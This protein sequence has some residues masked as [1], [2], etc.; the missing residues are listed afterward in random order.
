MDSNSRHQNIGMVLHGNVQTDIRVQNEINFLVS[1]GYN[2]FV[3]TPDFG[4]SERLSPDATY[5][6]VEVALKGKLKDIIFGMLNFIPIFTRYWT[7]AIIRFA[8]S[9]DIDLLHAH[10]LYMGEPTIAAAKKLRLPAVVGLHE[11]YPAAVLGYEWAKHP[12]KRWLARPHSWQRKEGPILRG[13]D[14]IIVLSDSYKDDLISRYPFLENKPIATYPNVPDVSSMMSF[15]HKPADTEVDGFCMLYFGLISRR[16]GLHV[17]AKAAEILHDKGIVCT[18]LAIGQVDKKETGYFENEV[19]NEH[20]VHIPWINLSELRSYVAN[21]DVCISPLIKNAQHESGVANK[22]YQYMLYEKPLLVSNCAPQKA[23]VDDFECGL[24]H[25]SED[26]IDFAK[27]LEYLI[28]NP[29][30]RR[31]MAQRGKAAVLETYNTA[32][33]GENITKLYDEVRKISEYN[34]INQS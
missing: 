8:Q 12:L 1:K 18:L 4:I 9:N 21:A 24:S 6:I 20:V 33:M 11:N 27:Q 3:L 25:E 16:R 15:D 28:Q 14:G 30:E 7:R 13:A 29:K 17:A 22:V 26:P 34:P 10:D 2:V 23:I 32:V 31:R 5:T 19:L